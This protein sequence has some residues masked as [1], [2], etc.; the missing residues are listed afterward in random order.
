MEF[1]IVSSKNF[2]RNNPNPITQDES[3]VPW[4]YSE[5]GTLESAR[6]RVSFSNDVVTAMFLV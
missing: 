2:I 3:T 1:K 4:M 5:K 6:D